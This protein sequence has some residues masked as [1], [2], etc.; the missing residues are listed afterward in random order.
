MTTPHDSLDLVRARLRDTHGF[1]GASLVRGTTG[2]L[3]IAIAWLELDPIPALPASVRGVPLLIIPR[4]ASAAEKAPSVGAWYD[5]W[6]Q[7][8]RDAWDEYTSTLKSYWS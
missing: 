6:R 5:P 8:G 7:A 3:V 4:S 2:K 1:L